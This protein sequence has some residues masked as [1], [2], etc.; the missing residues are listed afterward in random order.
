MQGQRLIRLLIINIPALEAWILQWT[1][2]SI[3]LHNVVTRADGLIN[4]GVIFVAN[5]SV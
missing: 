5:T 1:A 2:L 3:I 4:F